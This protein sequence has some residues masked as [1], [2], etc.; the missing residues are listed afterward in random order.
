MSGRAHPRRG[1]AGTAAAPG[2]RPPRHEELAGADR[3][4]PG[5]GPRL[6]DG[7]GRPHREDL[8]PPGLGNALFTG[9]A[10]ENG[11]LVVGLVTLSAIIFVFTNLIVDLLCAR[12]DPRISYEY[13]RP[14]S[15]LEGVSDVDDTVGG[16][17]DAVDR[18]LAQVRRDKR[19]WVAATLI[20]CSR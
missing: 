9:I 8:Q 19:F 4:D 2:R 14:T 10:T 15:Y 3:H 13:H 11:P 5:L 1:G 18:R 20:R 6:P 7:R 12:I 16:G 17:G